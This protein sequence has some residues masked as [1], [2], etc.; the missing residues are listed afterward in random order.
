[1]TVIL[2]KYHAR[3]EESYIRG[4][5]NQPFVLAWNRAAQRTS[6][7]SVVGRP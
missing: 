3:F 2:V 1:M 7:L 6:T 4:I 5:G